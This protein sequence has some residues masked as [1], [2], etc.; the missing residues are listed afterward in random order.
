M[1]SVI[2][3]GYHPLYQSNPALTYVATYRSDT[4]LPLLGGGAFAEYAKAE[5]WNEC[6]R[7]SL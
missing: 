2:F 5:H 4:A 1:L 3:A 7:P 6:D